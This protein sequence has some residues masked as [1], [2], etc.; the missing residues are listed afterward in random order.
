MSGAKRTNYGRLFFLGVE[1]RHFRRLYILGLLLFYSVLF[2]Y[3]GELVDFFGWEALRWSIFYSVHDIHRLFFLAPIL[4]SAYVFGVRA[5]IIITIISTMIFIPRALFIS[6]YPDPLVRMTI[7]SV[8]AGVMG[9]L[10]A[11]V[12]RES[13]KR[14]RLEALLMS[15]KDT[16]LGIL[17]RMADGVIIIGPDYRV[18]FMNPSM[19]RDFGEGI[20]SL[21]YKCLHGLDEPCQKICKLP[22]VIQGNT[23]KWEYSFPDGR[24]YE[25]QAS[26]YKDTDGVVC[27]FTTYRSITPR[28]DD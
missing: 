6:P 16:L 26:P 13:E 11:I 14:N 5:T 19:I 2:Y 3:F 23:E 18:R 22:S 1:S 21:C 17:G 28:K 20:G 9:Y 10:V 12:R 4:Y 7:F 25:V 24:T 8:I 27:Q 15:E